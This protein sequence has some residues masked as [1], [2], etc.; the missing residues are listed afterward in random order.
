[1]S[2]SL[3]NRIFQNTACPDGF[4]GRMILRGMNCFHASMA[5]WAMSLV[6]WQSDGIFLD[7]GCGGGANIARILQ[8]CPKSKVH[9]IDISEESVAFARK[10]NS[11]WIDKRCQIR[12]GD[13]K[14]LPYEDGKF[15]V[16]TAFETIY[17][18]K[19][20]P[21]AF[22][23]V[24]RVLRPGGMFLICC[25]A[26]DPANDVWTSRI[27]GMTVYSPVEL[28]KHLADAGFTDIILHRN[29]KEIICI[30]AHKQHTTL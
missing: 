9:G 3:I 25:E 26:S 20:L 12:L 1:M 6:R 13:V 28:Q 5:D 4:W 15:D 22:A 7:I 21:A 11:K 24:R 16:V 2:K 10:R 8:L 19:D 29:K 17:F 27:E 18:W 30:I 23:E 14:I